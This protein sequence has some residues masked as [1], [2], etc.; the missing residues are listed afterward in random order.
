MIKKHKRDPRLY[1]PW[2]HSRYYGLTRLR[3]AIEQIIRDFDFNG[4]VV[5]DYGCGSMPYKSMFDGLVLKYVGADIEE[6]KSAQILIDQHTGKIGIES[7]VADYV[8]STQVLEHVESPEKYLAEAHRVCAK[9]GKLIISTHGFW[10]YHPNP[11][12]YWRWTASG[13][14]KLLKDQKWEVEE[15]IGIFGFAAAS[16]AL[17]QDAVSIRLPSFLRTPFCVVMQQII[18]LVDRCYSPK[19]RQENATLYLI[20]A[21]RL[22]E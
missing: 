4:K 10:L 2:Y 14:K 3:K 5:L 1:P 8:L 7:N 11:T 17:F 15:I 6:N 20:V 16:L 22:N 18:N 9:G 13:L 19:G 21:K 12:D